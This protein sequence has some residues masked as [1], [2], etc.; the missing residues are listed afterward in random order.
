MGH[1]N[2]ENNNEDY[3]RPA[4]KKAGLSNDKDDDKQVSPSFSGHRKS[5][6]TVFEFDANELFEL[7]L[8]HGISEFICEIFLNGKS[9]LNGE[10]FKG[11]QVYSDHKALGEFLTEKYSKSDFTENNARHLFGILKKY[12]TNQKYN[13]KYKVIA[14]NVHGQ[15]SV[16]P[17]L[18]KII[19]TPQFQR[20]RYIKQLG[21]LCHVYPTGNHTRFEHSI[22]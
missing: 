22:G 10:Q 7:L 12:K 19:D 13:A 4:N 5:K 9:P 17:L 18:M 15:M 1:H 6:Q 8:S 16:H 11:W 3:T 20:L 21:C 2:D 14:D